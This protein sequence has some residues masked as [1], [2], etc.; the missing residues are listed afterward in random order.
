M[1]PPSR[2]S[3][4]GISVACRQIFSECVS[5]VAT[6]VL[7]I[8]VNTTYCGVAVTIV[9]V[10]GVVVVWRGVVV[11]GAA[12][13]AASVAVS[14]VRTADDGAHV[15]RADSHCQRAHPGPVSP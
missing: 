7:G 4:V 3:S 10:V 2:A 11:V 12:S 6:N 5:G 13:G 8:R 15:C 9:M 14:T 1:Q